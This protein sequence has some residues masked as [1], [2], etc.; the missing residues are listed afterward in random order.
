MNF[1]SFG[2]FTLHNKL[3]FVAGCLSLGVGS[4]ALVEAG[5]R[6]MYT[7]YGESLITHDDAPRDVVV[8]RLSLRQNENLL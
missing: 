7:L 1:I 4:R 8:D 5:L 2:I 3:K 6:S